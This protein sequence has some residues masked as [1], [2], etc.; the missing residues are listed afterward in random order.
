MIE[1]ELSAVLVEVVLKM[2]N[3]SSQQG[4]LTGKSHAKSL[5]VSI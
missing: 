1:V 5:K 4:N 2:G 3:S